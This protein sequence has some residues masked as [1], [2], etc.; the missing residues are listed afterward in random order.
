MRIAY[1]LNT[2]SSINWG[3][4]ATSA[5]LKLLVEQTYPQAEFVPLNLLGLPFKHFPLLR[6][7]YDRRLAQ[8]ILA[9]DRKK[10]E[11]YLRKLNLTL[12]LFDGFDTVCFNGEGS[13]HS[14]SGH[15][16]RLMGML[17]YFKQKGAFVSAANQTV[18]LGDNV[19]ARRVVA[20]VYQ[21]IDAVAVREPVSLRELAS[22]GVSAQLVP[23]A[24]YALPRLTRE[25]IDRHTADLNLPARFIGVTG[26]SALKPT[27][28]S[29][30]DF[31]LT[32]IREHYRL[33]IVFLANAKTDI[34]LAETLASRH[35]LLIIKPP[36]K[37]RQAMA[38]IARAHLIIG[39]RQHPNIFAA[40]HHV[41]FI[42]FRGNTH[43]M[44]GVVELLGYPLR[45][46]PW[47]K[48]KDRMQAAFA[49]ADHLYDTL[50]MIE[51]PC[52]N[53]LILSRSSPSCH[54]DRSVQ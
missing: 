37:Y 50:R 31:L 53:T 30:M 14:R 51:A 15:L 29:M 22:L 20:K 1:F 16:F 35:D 49:Q 13:V 2:M 52:V 44:D 42:P 4:Q 36:V 11:K 34:A 47:E 26:S 19:L 25:E 45:A 46:L 40:M 48:N 28:T 54:V 41:P 8:A 12:G 24:A 21:M 32:L 27:S 33:P 23:D 7:I 6:R 18:D 38:V 10:V 5:G 43:K 9:D 39:G 17:Y 3:G